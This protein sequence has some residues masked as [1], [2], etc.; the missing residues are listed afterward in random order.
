MIITARW[1]STAA[2]VALA[3]TSLSPAQAKPDPTP[4]VTVFSG[5]TEVAVFTTARCR[6]SKGDF[7]ALTPTVNGYRLFVS[8]E[9]FSGF[10]TYD[11]EQGADADPYAS[12][13]K[14]GETAFST[15]YVPPFPAPGFGQI[16]FR[17]K[18]KT[19][20]IGYQFMFNRDGTDGLVFAGALRCQYKKKGK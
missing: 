13:T 14:N 18:G 2:I 11:L 16:R 19:M 17:G 12:I 7:K 9:S 6:K 1:A 15:L 20:G 3:A 8:I 10:R 5:E 4:E